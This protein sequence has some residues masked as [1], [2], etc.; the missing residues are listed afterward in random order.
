MHK[1]ETFAG[2]LEGSSTLEAI[3]FAHNGGGKC[4]GE[5]CIYCN[6]NREQSDFDN[7]CLGKLLTIIDGCVPQGEQNKAVKD[8]IRSSYRTLQWD[9]SVAIEKVVL[10][11]LTK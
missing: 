11:H 7:D 6:L 4:T 2:S 5:S 1:A 9:K 3:G 8:L 10:R